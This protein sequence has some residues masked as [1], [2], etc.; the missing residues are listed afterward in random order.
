MIMRILSL[1]L[2]VVFA[3]SVS[4]QTP[5]VNQIFDEGTQAARVGNYENAIENYRR[6]I[7][8]AEVETVTDNFLAKIH[9]NIG[10]CLYNLKQTT[11]AAEEFTEA[12]KLSRRSY[13]K[14]FYALG[15]AQSD[16][17]N[18]R[19]AADAF[20]EAINLKKKDGEA[21]FDLGLVLLEEKDFESAE[22]A[23]RNAIKFKSIGA[24]DAHNNLGVILALRTDFPSAESEF[25]TALIESNGKSVEAS[26]NLRFCKLYKR[27]FNQN[28]LAKLEF[29]K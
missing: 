17:K 6:A 22:K 8:L 20:R 7:L 29:T 5:L 27:S 21:W 10:V 26:N 15:M 3:V 25:K 12:I 1:F 14:A 2:T 11:E 4:A 23:F 13:Q 9:F 18:W 24:A 28:L 16:L 19:E